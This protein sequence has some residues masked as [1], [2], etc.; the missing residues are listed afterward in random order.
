[1]GTAEASQAHL[2][3]KQLTTLHA[4]G[5][6]LALGPI[7]SAALFIG[8]ISAFAGFSTPVSILLGGLGVLALGYVIVLYARR[9]AGAGSMYEYLARGVHPW[10]G[11]LSAGIYFL[12]MLLLGA[13]GVYVGLGFLIKGFFNQHLSSDPPFFLCGIVALLIVLALNHFG[14]RLAVRGVLLLAAF[15]IIP[16]VILAITIIVKGGDAGNTLHAFS[17]SGVGWNGPVFK[18]ILIAVTLFI[19]FEAAAAIAEET[20]NPHRSVP[21]AVLSTVAIATVFYV[22]MGYAV[23]I[24]FGSDA[25]A[26]GAAAADPDALGTLAKHYDGWF[27][28][29]WIDL[30]VIT[31]AIS[32]SVAFTVS[33]TRGVFALARDGLL[34][35]FLATTSSHDTPL[36]GNLVSFVFSVGFLAWASVVHY[37]AGFGLPDTL[38][39]FQILSL[40]GSFMIELIYVFLALGAFVLIFGSEPRSKWWWQ[41]PVV[42][43]ALLTPLAA[44]KGS[45]W[46]WPPDPIN[47]GIYF[48]VAG[49]VIALVWAIGLQV[50]KPDRVR[51][52]AAYATRIEDVAPA[53]PVD[54]GL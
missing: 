4:I 22:L 23:M 5:Q 12:G 36:G 37:G 2:G 52:A 27:L 44:Y 32:L 25:I 34:P 45:L 9:F 42:V 26:K 11:V 19:G 13:G 49:G 35:R 14:V 39:A 6:S 38:A 41:L 28:R 50:T 31:D 7:F 18:G 1:M 15:S 43:I 3:K 53:A 24:G 47:R 16:L 17:F 29:G 46:P 20:P 10:V 33:A 40:A 48:A 51:N 21:I 8:F 54:L 30:V